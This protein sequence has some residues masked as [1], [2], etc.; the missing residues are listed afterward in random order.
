VVDKEVVPVERVRLEKD[1]DITEEQVGTDVRKERIELDD[2]TQR[3][4]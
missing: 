2:D 3:R 4:T 1:V